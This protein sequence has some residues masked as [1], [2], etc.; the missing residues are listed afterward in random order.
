MSKKIL[1]VI[2]TLKGGGAEKV[3][4]DILKNMD[5]LKYKTEIFLIKNEGFYIKK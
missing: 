1:F 4:Y 2:D 3:L 5:L